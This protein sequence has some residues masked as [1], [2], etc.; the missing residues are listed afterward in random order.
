MNK[1]VLLQGQW[2]AFVKAFGLEHVQEH[3]VLTR[4]LPG[5]ERQRFK[6]IV[7]SGKP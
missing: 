5:E 3:Y 7:K 4:P 2:D 6:Y 1:L